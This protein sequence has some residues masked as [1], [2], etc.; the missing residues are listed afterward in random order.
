MAQQPLAFIG[1]GA[2]EAAAMARS[3]IGG[4]INIVRYYTGEPNS[5]S[6]SEFIKSLE[7]ASRL[8]MWTHSQLVTVMQTRLAGPAASFFDANT[9]LEQ[10]TWPE[11]K[12][13]FMEFFDNEASTIDPFAEFHSCIQRPGENVSLF[14]LRLKK[15]GEKAAKAI[16]QPGQPP[17]NQLIEGMLLPRFLQGLRTEN[18]KL[19][20]SMHK[21]QT[22]KEAL[23]LA[24]M[25]SND[26]DVSTAKVRMLVHNQEEDAPKVQVLTRGEITNPNNCTTC[27]GRGHTSSVCPT[28]SSSTRTESENSFIADL[29]NLLQLQ[30][31]NR[32]QAPARG[33][34]VT[35]FKCQQVGHYAVNCNA[36]TIKCNYCQKLG[37]HIKNCRKLQYNQTQQN[38]NFNQNPIESQDVRSETVRFPTSNRQTAVNQNK[39]D[40]KKTEQGF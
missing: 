38:S 15:L 7:S 2:E 32:E 16:A 10:A 5:T 21:P 4:V 1:V 39:Q 34:N 25:F 3:N 17:Q 11:I 19:M 28:H 14:L 8:G 27:G 20:I 13:R 29:R 37:H 9:D 6:V 26:K 31:S 24:K 30:K 23:E 18:G 33:A 12:S 22:L 40:E 35:C 36:I